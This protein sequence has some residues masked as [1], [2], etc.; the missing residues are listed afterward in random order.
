MNNWQPFKWYCPN[1]GQLIVAY[2]NSKGE[3]KQTCS[4]CETVMF[5][6]NKS[7]RFVSIDM[8]LPKKIAI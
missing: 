2:K 5:R 6:L 4:K 1:C 3:I 8:K 7:R